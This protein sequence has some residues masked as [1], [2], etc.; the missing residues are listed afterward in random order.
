MVAD[1]AA[2]PRP[3]RGSAGH[4]RGPRRR[5]VACAAGPPRAASQ[6]T[7]ASDA[8]ARRRGG[9]A[10]CPRPH[11]GKHRRSPGRML[12]R[13]RQTR[14][15][16]LHRHPGPLHLRGRHGGRR[17]AGRAVLLQPR[18]GRGGARSR[19][20]VRRMGGAGPRPLCGARRLRP[21]RRPR[22]A[23]RAAPR[24]PRRA[25][26]DSWTRH[27]GR[28]AAGALRHHAC[29]RPPASKPRTR[30]STRP[31]ALGWPVALKTTD[32]ALR[33]RLDLGGVRLDIEDADSLR[34]N[35]VQMRALA[36]TLRLAVPGGAVHGPGGPGLHVPG[37]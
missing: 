32:P 6:D 14:G 11:G 17:A 19:G 3:G 24:R 26:Q 27:R 9:A 10:A 8:R 29:C 18:R 4:R 12:G 37:H 5:H 23:G 13:G 35:I 22:R 16:C 36:G 31:Q 30:P 25:A 33:H 2:G 20:P 34:R 28:V 7:L 15:G 21:G 1:S